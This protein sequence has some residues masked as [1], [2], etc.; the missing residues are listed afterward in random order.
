MGERRRKK[1]FIVRNRVHESWYFRARLCRGA[2][3][4]VDLSTDGHLEAKLSICAHLQANLSTIYQRAFRSFRNLNRRGV[5]PLVSVDA[6]A[7]TIRATGASP[8]TYLWTPSGCTFPNGFSHVSS[9]GFAVAPGP[10]AV[11]ISE[12]VFLC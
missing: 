2:H 5:P 9:R 1:N 3:C 7:D 10:F 4:E 8:L 6:F 12:Q 11:H